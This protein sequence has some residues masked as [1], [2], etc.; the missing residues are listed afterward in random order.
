MIILDHTYTGKVYKLLHPQVDDIDIRDIAHHL[1]RQCR[2]G[3]RT[4]PFYCV[5]PET[6]ILTY[7][8][9]WVPAGSIASGDILWGFDEA[10]GGHRRLRKWRPSIASV[11]G[12][13]KRRLIEL[14]FGD[15]TSVRCSREHPLL[16]SFKASGNQRWEVAWKIF[17]RFSKGQ[18]TYLP[19][20]LPVW[21]T[22]GTW[23]AGW[24]AG[25]FD[26]EGCISSK[27]SRGRSLG[28]SQNEGVLFDLLVRA[29]KS[30][31]V[32]V[33]CSYQGSYRC[34]RFTVRGGFGKQLALL[35][36]IRPYRLIGRMQNKMV[37]TDVSRQGALLPVIDARDAGVG[38]VVAIE[39]STHTYLTEGF[40]SHNSVAEH[41]VM[42]SKIVNPMWAK[43]G[44][45][46]DA[47]EAYLLDIPAPLKV[48]LGIPY[49]KLEDKYMQVISKKFG[50]EWPMV[51]VIYD[52]VKRADFLALI[53][54]R[55]NFITDRTLN[56][57][58]DLKPLNITITPL[59]YRRAEKA[60]LK[61]FNELFG[62]RI[63][64]VKN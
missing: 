3:G 41:C 16:C 7:D 40:G 17:E 1:A 38:S 58:V 23:E 20:L 14:T 59:G 43:E 18:T 30:R 42:V 4:E 56:Y 52:H 9:R 50:L 28:I 10:N 36:S 44:L 63:E 48:F 49:K 24:L 57:G 53:T 8:Y 31:Y 55:E 22:D 32:D 19:K 21:A 51:D 64:D 33:Q 61:R 2:F 13:I 37:G 29:F 12:L 47:A 34:K 54:E 11:H 27:N 35:G 39:T 60:F 5:T 6:K 45:L 15:G 46:H 26:G 25:M 62:E